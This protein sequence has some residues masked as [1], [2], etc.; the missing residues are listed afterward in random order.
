[1]CA[2][3]Y[4][5]LSVTIATNT[6]LPPGSQPPKKWEEFGIQQTFTK[7]TKCSQ[8]LISSAAHDHQV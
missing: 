7:V 5:K 4:K 1:M 8:S 2:L 6:T 3:F